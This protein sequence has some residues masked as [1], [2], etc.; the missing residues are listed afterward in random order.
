M[1]RIV[2]TGAGGRMGAA[3]VRHFAARGPVLALGRAEANLADPAA[4]RERLAG[5]QFS[6]LIN[7]AA[8]TNVDRCETHPQEAQTVN[9]DAVGVLAEVCAGKNARLLQISTDYVFA[10]N[11]PGTVREEDPAEP[12]SVY[13]RSKRAGELLALAH[14]RNVV[15]RVSWVFG[16]DRPSF[17][18]MA[19]GRALA[20]ER[21][22]AIGDKYSS[23]SYAIDLA[24]WIEALLG[25]RAPGGLVHLCNAGVCSW[26]DYAQFALDELARA[27]VALRTHTVIPT[28][29]ADM[30]AF[31]A[32]RPVHTAL[33]TARFTAWT[34][35]APR[36][37]TEAVAAYLHDHVIPR[38]REGSGEK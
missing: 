19:I 31:V 37:W 36:P 8:L 7:C 4:L 27:G 17:L 3:L 35:I 20:E 25:S 38:L 21:V 15:A 5:E 9:A 14:P 12:R 29:V 26:K 33:D 32:E 30:R 22:E 1:T 34:G 2:I 24:S 23:P 11:R 28:R 10:G 6:T 18:D 16:P 13:G